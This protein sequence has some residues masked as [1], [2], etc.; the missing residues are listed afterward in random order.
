MC[1]ALR[2]LFGLESAAL[3]AAAAGAVDLLVDAAARHGDA[4][5]VLQAV[6]GA[7]W[8][9]SVVEEAVGPIMEAGGAGTAV[10]MA[11]GSPNDG[12]LQA[13]CAAVLRNLAI[14]DDVRRSIADLGALEVAR[15]RNARPHAL[16]AVQADTMRPPCD[17][18]ATAA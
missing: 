8:A 1:D 10:G 5:A 16:L 12:A 15:A 9:L 17:R 4:P 2:N 14:D 7:L 18:R 6:G 11:R 13:S 3:A